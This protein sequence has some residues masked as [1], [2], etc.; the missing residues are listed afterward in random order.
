MANYAII[1][2]ET[3]VNV[4]VADAEFIAAHY[5]D[6]VVCAESFGVGDEHKKG[7]FVKVV[8]V[9]NDEPVS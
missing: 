3:I 6:A 8:N 9:S 7:K 2:N 5:P 4:I 1:E